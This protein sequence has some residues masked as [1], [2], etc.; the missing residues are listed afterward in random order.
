MLGCNDFTNSETVFKVIIAT[1][2]VNSTIFFLKIFLVQ[3]Y[4]CALEQLG[5][6]KGCRFCYIY[7]LFKTTCKTKIDTRNSKCVVS[8]VLYQL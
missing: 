4:F 3:S 1:G 6:A 2:Y 7:Q 5:V 8:H